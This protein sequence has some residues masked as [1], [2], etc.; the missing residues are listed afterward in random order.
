METG[1]PDYLIRRANEFSNEYFDMNN[2]PMSVSAINNMC[3][4]LDRAILLLAVAKVK[5]KDTLD[6]DY[7]PKNI[8]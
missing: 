1:N 4:K 7:G 6:N 3:L 8:S 2:Q 5:L